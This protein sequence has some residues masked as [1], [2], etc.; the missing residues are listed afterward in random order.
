MSEREKKL[1][2]TIAKAVTQLPGGKREFLLG[3]AEGVAAMAAKIPGG[4][5]LGGKEARKDE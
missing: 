2:D 1:A 4:D 3:Y 5:T